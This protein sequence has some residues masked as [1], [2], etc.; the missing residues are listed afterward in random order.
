MHCTIDLWDFWSAKYYFRSNDRFRILMWS[1]T[2]ITSGLNFMRICVIIITLSQQ[3][4]LEVL[5]HYFKSDSVLLVTL[6]MKLHL[7]S[8]N[9]FQHHCSI[10]VLLLPDL[11]QILLIAI[12]SIQTLIAQ[13]QKRSLKMLSSSWVRTEMHHPSSRSAHMTGISLTEFI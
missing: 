5:G 8:I 10:R 7:L 6:I 13:S 9:K 12:F 4:M 3:F 11:S 1:T 2:C